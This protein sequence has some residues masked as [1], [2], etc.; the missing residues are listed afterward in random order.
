MECHRAKQKEYE[1]KDPRERLLKRVA[2]IMGR[3]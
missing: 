2:R 1:A 3:L